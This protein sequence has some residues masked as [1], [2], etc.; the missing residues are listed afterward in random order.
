MAQI[1]TIGRIVHY[2]HR[3]GRSDCRPAI[4]VHVW[5]HGAEGSACQLQVF[6]DSDKDGKFNDQRLPIE[7]QTSV[8]QGAELGQFHFYEDCPNK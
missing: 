4:I 2:T 6:N 8:M 5:T 3:D 1:P 7:W